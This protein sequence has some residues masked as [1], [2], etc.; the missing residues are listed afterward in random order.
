M[1][2]GAGISGSCI[3]LIFA[4]RSEVL[5]A[6][7][8][9]VQQ[10][11]QRHEVIDALRGFALIGVCMVN[12][13]SLTLYDFLDAIAKKSLP[14]SGFDAIAV[15]AIEWL[16]NV[17][18]ITIFSLLFG[19]GFALQLQRAASNGFAGWWQY[20]KR[21][22][23]LIIIGWIHAW[24]VWWGDILLTYAVVGLLLL[25]FR[26]VPDR[27]LLISGIAIALL[28][29]LVAPYV[30]PLLTGL[31]DEPA[32]YARSLERFSSADWGDVLNAN[33]AMSEWAR[34]SN[35]ALVCFVLGRFLLGYWAGRKGLQFATAENRPVLRRILCGA[36]GLGIG[37]AAL[38]YFQPAML[39]AWPAMGTGAP[40]VLI[41]MLLRIAPLAL[42]IAYAAGFALLFYRAAWARRLRVLAPFG[43]MA[44]SNYVTQSFLG[45]A[46]FYGVGFGIGPRFGM[47]GVL[48]ACA[49]TV[50]LQMWWSRVWLSHFTHGPLEWLWR[51]LTHGRRPRFRID[52]S[53]I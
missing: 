13:A 3:P 24:F 5:V 33:M 17:K 49:F 26:H 19:L 14:T 40:R 32:L 25:P 4:D 27:A 42:G 34:L 43:R 36:L 12:L 23:V 9:T 37:A 1:T 50:A 44:L 47:I 35:W 30:R 52:A 6:A 53:T 21:M 7:F 38:S 20:L 22:L 45:I 2:R 16:V 8:D 29:P 15:P 41:R 51:W 48:V 46:L 10:T 31:F 28:P 11:N 18:F 39:A